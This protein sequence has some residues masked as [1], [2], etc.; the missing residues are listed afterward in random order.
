MNLKSINK[1]FFIG[2]GGIGMSSLA[3]YFIKKNIRVIG[4]DREETFI[5]KDLVK[6]GANIIYDVNEL[7]VSEFIKQK[8]DTL[9]VYTPA[10][11]ATHPILEVFNENGFKIC[12]RSK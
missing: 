9:V 10:I 2:I 7:I 5:T 8:K 11:S 6:L 12:K 4:Y 3:K 1:V